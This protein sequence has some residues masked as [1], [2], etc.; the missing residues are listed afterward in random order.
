MKRHD[1]RGGILSLIQAEDAY[2]RLVGLL[3]LDNVF[4]RY[5]VCC[6]LHYVVLAWLIKL[7]TVG[8]SLSSCALEAASAYAKHLSS[9]F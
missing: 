9:L 7:R 5:W 3:P 2:S 4:D 1:W 6:G 8:L